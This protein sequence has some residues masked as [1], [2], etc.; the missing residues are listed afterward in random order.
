MSTAAL[1][2]A[3]VG[4]LKGGADGDDPAWARHLQLE[5]GVVGDGH[6]LYV[7]RSP[8]NGVVDQGE[9]NYLEGEGLCPIVG[10]IPEGDGQVD[11]PDWYGL[12]SQHDAVEKRPGRPDARS[13]DADGIKCLYVNDV[14]ATAPVHQYLG[15][16]LRADDRVDHEQV[17]DSIQVV[18]SVEG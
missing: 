13:V 6:E 3:L 16:P 15:E 8:Q 18:G 7:T 2:F 1:D 9:P 4:M 12:L 10:W 17:C 14:E 5:V 11:L